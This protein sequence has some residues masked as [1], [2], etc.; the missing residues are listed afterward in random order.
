M[1]R[2]VGAREGLLDGMLVG[3]MDGRNTGVSDMLGDIVAL[4]VG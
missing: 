1:G 2:N 3:F 4:P